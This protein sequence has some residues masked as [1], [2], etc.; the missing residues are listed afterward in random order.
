MQD[1]E[2]RPAAAAVDRHR[3]A[4][5]EPAPTRPRRCWR[6]PTA[7][8]YEVKKGHAERTGEGLNAEAEEVQSPPLSRKAGV[9]LSI[10]RG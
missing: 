7:S 9:T 8:L 3:D 4:P 1:D 6:K 2:S 10:R 5:A